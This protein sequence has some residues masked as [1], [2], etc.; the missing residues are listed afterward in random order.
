MS[1]SRDEI[2]RA[3]L[4]LDEADRASLVGSLLESL[5]FESD[6]GAE[7]AWA[8]EIERRVADLDSGTAVTL[9]WDEV[10]A[11]LHREGG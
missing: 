1:T 8:R 6:D 9:S 10:R 4:E 5:E 7:A 3:A 2:Y 11:K